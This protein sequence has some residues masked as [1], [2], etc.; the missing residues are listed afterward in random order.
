MYQINDAL[1]APCVLPS[2]FCM[3]TMCPTCLLIQELHHIN[4]V[5]AGAIPAP[6]GVGKGGVVVVQ[7]QMM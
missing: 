3:M 5:A 1:D 7:Q 2:A 4:Q 6:P